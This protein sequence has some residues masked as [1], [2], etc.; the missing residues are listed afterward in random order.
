MAI[1]SIVTLV[2]HTPTLPI[3]TR[4]LG[5]RGF[6]RFHSLAFP[7]SMALCPAINFAARAGLNRALIYTCVAVLMLVEVLATASI[8]P[9]RGIE[10]GTH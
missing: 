2:V 10:P 5:Q 6:L 3:R 7:I 8:C 4:L 9:F 1:K